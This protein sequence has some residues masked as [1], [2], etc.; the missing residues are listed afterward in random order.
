[1]REVI[2]EVIVATLPCY[3]CLSPC[4]RI[5]TKVLDIVITTSMKT[6]IVNYS[7]FLLKQVNTILHK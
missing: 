7:L 1:M 5:C 3:I 6:T 4:E 2:I